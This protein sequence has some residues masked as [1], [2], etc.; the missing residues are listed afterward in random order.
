MLPLLWQHGVNAGR[1]TAN[2]AVGLLAE[3][4]ARVFG[5][6]PRK[7]R[8]EEGADAD[9]VVFDPAE[10]WTIRLDNQHSNC[11]YTLY[12]GQEI[13]GRVR[14]VLA[15]GETIVERGEFL[16]RKGA[17]RFLPTRAG[18]ELRKERA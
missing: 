1:I 5:L 2:E 17:G 9:L 14:Q 6:L 8:L 13:L 3:N 18:R 11:P 16:G 4:A 12:E 10:R 7:G 15:R